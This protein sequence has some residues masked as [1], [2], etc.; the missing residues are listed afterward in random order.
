[1]KG[2]KWAEEAETVKKM[3]LK[4]EPDAKVSNLK[5]KL[6]SLSIVAFFSILDRRK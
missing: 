6:S 3:I 4:N 5:L 1:M 2:Q